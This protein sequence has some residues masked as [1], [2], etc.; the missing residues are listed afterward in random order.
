M[1]LIHRVEATLPH[2][3]ALLY[4]RIAEA[5]LESIDTFRGVYSG[6]YNLPQ[7][8]RWLARVGYEM[9]RRRKPEGGPGESELL[10]DSSEV[11]GWLDEEMK[12]GGTSAG[13]STPKE[14]LVL[15]RS[16]ER[17]VPAT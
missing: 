4:D 7:K 11:T 5:Y 2:G 9:Q 1:A 13:L 14:F 8:K 6:A 10:V 3:R 15:R 17:P 12:R 16:E